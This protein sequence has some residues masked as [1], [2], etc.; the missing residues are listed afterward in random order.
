MEW[1]HRQVADLL[2]AW[3]RA[4]NDPRTRLLATIFERIE[5]VAERGGGLGTIAVPRAD[6]RPFFQVL[7]LELHT[8]SCSNLSEVRGRVA[9]L[10]R[11]A[12]DVL[13]K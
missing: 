2:E 8:W 11:A 12:S 6:W 9:T 1:C 3:D 4:D 10:S 5:A 13:V 7:T